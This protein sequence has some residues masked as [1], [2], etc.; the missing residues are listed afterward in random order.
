MIQRATTPA[1]QP[2]RNVS[3]Y[4]LE[5]LGEWGVRRIFGYPGDGINGLMGALRRAGDTFE[6]VQTAHEEIAALAASAYAKFSGELGVCVATSG[7]GAIHLLN[8]LYDAKL[9][10][11]PVLAIVGQQ[12]LAGLGGSMQQEVNLRAIVEDVA[13]YTELISSPEQVRHVIDRAARISLGDR[14]VSVIILPHD[15]QRMKP[16]DQPEHKHGRAHSGAG[17]AAPR[18]IPRDEDLRRAADVLNAGN[19]IA[20]LVG[21]G[22]L[23][24]TDEILQTAELLGAG[25]AKSLLGKAAVPDDVPYV[26]GSVGWLG[27]EPSN[28]MMKECDTLFMVGSS[29]P[30]TEYLPK[31][32]QARGVQVDIDPASLSLRYPM[33]VSLS[34][35]SVETLRALIPLLQRKT[36]RKW[37]EE[38]EQNVRE[39][40]QAV[41]QRAHAPA[42]PLNPKLPVWE[43]AQRLPN[44]CIITADCG[45]S[46]VWVARDVRIRR[47]MMFSLSGTLAT[48]G[49]ALPYALAAKFAH[50]E[51]TVFAVVGDGAMQMNGISVLID[52]AKYWE[53]WRDPRLIVLVMNN[54]DLNYVTWEQ[55][56]MEGEPKFEGSQNLPDFQYAKYAELL[57][58]RGIRVERPDQVAGAWD[59]AL[60]ATR[61]TVIEAVVNADVPPLPPELTTEQE[62]HLATALDA[63]DP[64]AEW[65]EVQLVEQ[66]VHGAS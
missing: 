33:E 8:G 12:A 45:S 22:A 47:G 64:D 3:D 37:R 25:V 19:R 24:A 32:G 5:R 44:D 41:D 34:G 6:F 11:Q 35:D 36:D 1:T 21:S 13:C 18:M 49:G 23:A 28:R 15:V 59:E 43:M 20:M 62:E 38:I 52:I 26:T 57:G 17:Y 39:W 30:Y 56:V 58:L 46:T 7:P 14:G 61:P 48:M 40:W 54:R 9:D 29:F 27:T 60:H 2:K 16:V 42:P 50:S 31:E 53:R 55:R 51:R 66:G 65:V 63:G 10:H 4:V